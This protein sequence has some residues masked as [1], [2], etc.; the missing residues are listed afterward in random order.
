M[1][2]IDY[3]GKLNTHE[4][5]IEILKKLNEKTKYIEIVLL[6]KR[7]SNSLTKEFKKY[8]IGVEKVD[9]WWGTITIDGKNLKLRIKAT[10]NLFD[11][12]KKY[13][14]FC[15]YY[16][17]G[18][19][20]KT[21]SRGDYSE[22]TDFGIDDIAFFDENDVMLLYTTTHEGYITIRSDLR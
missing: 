1:E 21:L 17:Y 6:G 9:K 20:E 16:Y 19:N 10:Q 5:Y 11:K 8:I 2:Y 18:E 15:K 13:E 14:T 3:T 22:I 12:L 7:E 4:K